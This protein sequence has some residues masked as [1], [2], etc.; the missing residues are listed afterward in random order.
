MIDQA[1]HHLKLNSFRPASD[2]DLSNH[3]SRIHHCRFNGDCNQSAHI[4]DNRKEDMS[5]RLPD[6]IVHP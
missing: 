6:R 1:G 5:V 3:K 2:G 4:T